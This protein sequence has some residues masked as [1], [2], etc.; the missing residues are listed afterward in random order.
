[1]KKFIFTLILAIFSISFLYGQTDTT[2]FDGHWE[3]TVRTQALFYRLPLISS[4]KGFLIRDFY[5]SGA[6]QFEGIT[7]SQDSDVYQDKVT[8]FY[9]NGKF[10]KIANYNNGIKQGEFINYDVQGNIVAEGVYK[11]DNPYEGSFVSSNEYVT[12]ILYYTKGG[13]IRS[14]VFGNK[15]GSKA[16]ITSLFFPGTMDYMELSF[17]NQKGDFVGKLNMKDNEPFDGVLVEYKFNP[18]AVESVKEISE[19]K[20]KSPVK[21]YYSNGAIKKITHFENDYYYPFKEIYFTPDGKVIDTLYLNEGEPQNGL[22]IDFFD[23]NES[24]RS[25]KIEKIVY[26]SN[27]EL[28]GLSK[29]YYPNGK[30]FVEANYTENEIDGEMVTYDSIG[31]KLYTLSYIDGEPWTGIYSDDN[32]VKT[33]KEGVIT[34]EKR[35]HFNGKPSY[36]LTSE[37]IE[38]VYDTTG[39][40]LARLQYK[41]GEPYDGKKLSMYNDQIELE[42]VY[43]KGII[44][45]SSSYNEGKLSQTSEYE[46]GVI[47][48]ENNG[49]PSYI[50]TSEGSET[51]YDTTGNE[52]AR[53]QY[54]DGEPYDGKKLSMYNDQIES[55]E[56]YSKGVKIKSS[57]YN[58]G[59]LSQTSEYDE[60]GNYTKDI[61]YYTSGKTK[62]E[63]PYYENGDKKSTL[64]FNQDGK[65]IGKLTINEEGVYNG[66]EFEFSGDD[67][68]E[69]TLYNADRIMRTWKYHE[70]QLI[71]DIQSNGI[72]YFYDIKNKK[73][74]QCTY[75]DKRPFDGTKFEYSYYDHGITELASYKNGKLDGEFSEFEFIAAGENENLSNGGFKP[76][77]I[78]NYKEGRKEGL[79]KQFYQ[80]KLIKTMN[81]KDDNLNGELK[82]YDID[83]KVVSTVIYKDDYPFQGV[84]Y[85]YDSYHQ[86][87]SI[88]IY[89]NGNMDGEQKYFENEKLVRIELYKNGS[90]LKKIAYVQGKEYELMYKNSEPFSG[91]EA[92]TYSIDEYKNGTLAFRKTFT[93]EEQ[94][95]LESIE[96]YQGDTSVKETYFDNGQKKEEISYLDT[97][98][99]GKTVF[100]GLNGK[101]LAEGNYSDDLPASGKFVYYSTEN[102]L[103]YL[104]LQIENTNFQ[105][106]EYIAG[107]QCRKYQYSNPQ[108]DNSDSENDE[109]KIFLFAIT[110]LFKDYNIDIDFG[111]NIK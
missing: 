37:G 1:M 41:D 99:E 12:Q 111:L 17:Y 106:T 69:H 52:L 5:I 81:Y 100:Y 63:V 13:I 93:D 53:L 2:F 21:Y 109:L 62:K 39:N 95:K 22:K 104:I 83:G 88:N 78:I 90:I 19:G 75:K 101:V 18:M 89:N 96:I 92:D 85:D 35:F 44:I 32:N 34:E 43:S 60:A 9:E 28:N 54:K 58:Y 72:S 8:W 33:Y 108:P 45:K 65:Q 56:V 38:T 105:A 23:S 47:T 66:D 40:E 59:K 76:E 27:G 51:V 97:E 70:G 73:T 6:K 24:T 20:I 46:E 50:L 15:T 25:D 11:D 103:S 26:Y 98:K 3:K 42:E 10:E 86:V 71:S 36:I 49:K 82:L 67:I 55:E 107:K 87:T 91:K 68:E 57:S 102:E 74:Y 77:R 80:G 79:A 29:K 14:E 64:Y 7:L 61:Y 48:E 84:L 16:K 4:G 30:L 94:T 110:L 31:N